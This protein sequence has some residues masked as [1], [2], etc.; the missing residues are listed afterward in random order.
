[1][2]FSTVIKASAA[3][4]ITIWDACISRALSNQTAGPVTFFG[5]LV[6]N[7]AYQLAGT[8]RHS[9]V[10]PMAILLA[11]ICLVAG[12]TVLERLFAFN[13]ALSVIIEFLGGITF[14]LL[15]LRTKR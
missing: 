11:I 5:L 8:S 3:V 14:I 4:A 2:A 10:L 13:T 7:L 6:A 9:I 15:L 12:Q 1:M